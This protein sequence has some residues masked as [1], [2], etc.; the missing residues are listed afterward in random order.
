M[1]R[2]VNVE[3]AVSTAWLGEHSHFRVYNVTFPEKLM[4]SK[5]GSLVESGVKE[6]SGIRG[7]VASPAFGAMMTEA[8]DQSSGTDGE[9]IPDRHLVGG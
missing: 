3:V 6:E 5:T 8:G 1:V 7:K 9:L 2:M 4:D